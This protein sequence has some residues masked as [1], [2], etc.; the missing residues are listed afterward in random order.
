MYLEQLAHGTALEIASRARRATLMAQVTMG[1]PDLPDAQ[2]RLD[3]DLKRHLRPAPA[4]VGKV[5]WSFSDPVFQAMRQV[6]HLDL[7]DIAFRLDAAKRHAAQ[8]F[9]SPEPVARCNIL[10]WNPQNH[11]RI[12]ISPCRE[13]L[14]P[15]GPLHINAPACGIT[16]TKDHVTGF[17]AFRHRNQSCWVVREIRI[18]LAHRIYIIF[19]H[20]A[21][22]LHVG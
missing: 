9:R 2:S 1:Q 17:Q 8:R 21:E 15:E 4:P 12:K 10:H 13:Y 3:L 18:H 11:T 5:N 7:E 6:S 14:A 19:Q 20:T 16:R 22:S